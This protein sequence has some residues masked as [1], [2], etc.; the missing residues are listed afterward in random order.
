MY[1]GNTNINLILRRPRALRGRL[2][3]WPRGR[4]EQV[5]I[6]RDGGP[7]GRPP[8][9]EVCENLTHSHQL[10]LLKQG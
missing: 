9:D 8:Q 3:G 1:G 10:A 5:A 4:A 2:E 6:L 7:K